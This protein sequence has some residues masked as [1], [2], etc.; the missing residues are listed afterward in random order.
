[1]ELFSATLEQMIFLFGFIVIGF[2]LR[3]VGAVPSGSAAILSKLENCLFIPALVLGT[4]I[5]NFTLS[6]IQVAWKTL[7]FSL[8]VELIVIPVTLVVCKCV[9]RDRYIQKIYTYGLCFSNFSFMGNAVVSAIFPEYFTTY[10]IFTLVLWAVIYIYGVP[11]LLLPSENGKQTLKTRL[12]AFVN[13]MFAAMLIGM[14]LGIIL[15]N[16]QLSMP[17]SVMKIITVSGDCMSP[18]AMLL[19][20]I[21]M[22]EIDLKKVLKRPSIYVVSVLRLVVYPVISLAI[23]AFAAKLGL[24]KSYIIC[25]VCTLAMPLGLNTV[26]IPAAYGKDTSTAAGMALISHFLSIITIPIIFMLL[27]MII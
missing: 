21:T 24:D 22:A 8:V 13:P 10:L 20:G 25:T 1:M 9:T 23:F 6:T 14:V 15:S 7:L 27:N 11:V 26:V 18:V 16:F 2:I 5:K 3:K 17:D 4:F 19:T 12:K